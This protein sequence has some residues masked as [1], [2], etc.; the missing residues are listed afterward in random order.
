MAALPAN[1]LDLQLRR[2]GTSSRS[3][4]GRAPAATG[5]TDA[6]AAQSMPATTRSPDTASFRGS[7]APASSSSSS[8]V[9]AFVLDDPL[10]ELLGLP[11]AKT[12]SESTPHG[13]RGN[14][15]FVPPSRVG[16][17][18]GS[19]LASTRSFNPPRSTGTPPTVAA[20]GSVSHHA[21]TG[22]DAARPPPAQVAP[23]A[24]VGSGFVA[25][26]TLALA[27]APPRSTSAQSGVKLDRT[28]TAG[29][30]HL[31]LVEDAQMLAP[32]SLPEDFGSIDDA[33]FDDLQVDLPS[34]PTTRVQSASSRV[35]P[36]REHE[37][38]AP[39]A[40]EDEPILFAPDTQLSS[41]ENESET[42]RKQGNFSSTSAAAMAHPKGPL[43]SSRFSH[44]SSDDAD[45]SQECTQLST[46]PTDLHRV[47][48]LFLEDDV[49][50]F[51]MEEVEV[52]LNGLSTTINAL[53]NEICNLLA[54][55]NGSL[56]LPPDGVDRLAMRERL[57]RHRKV[58][59]SRRRALEQGAPV[60]KM[61]SR[62][63]QNGTGDANGTG[64]PAAT[65]P[66]TL[67]TS[68]SSF[69]LSKPGAV[70]P[71]SRFQSSIVSVVAGTAA[72]P[73]SPF[74]S[75]SSIPPGPTLTRGA[76]AAAGPA[77]P[78][79]GAPTMKDAVTPSPTSGGGGGG[80]VT[81]FSAASKQPQWPPTLAKQTS[82]SSKQQP[83]IG[84]ALPLPLSPVHA[85]ATPSLVDLVS[86]THSASLTGAKTMPTMP[87]FGNA[88]SRMVMSVDSPLST[89]TTT[90]TTRQPETPSVYG[91][92]KSSAA[93]AAAA[94]A[95]LAAAEQDD[96]DANEV[97]SLDG[98]D[99]CDAYSQ[100]HETTDND[101]HTNADMGFNGTSGAGLNGA[102]S[103]GVD[104][105]EFHFD[106]DDDQ[107]F[108]MVDLDQSERL[109]APPTSTIM[110]Y[111]SAAR[112]T[113]TTTMGSASSSQIVPLSARAAQDSAAKFNRTDY[114]WSGDVQ[115]A[116]RKVFGLN[117]GFRTHQL[118]VINCTMS[119][120]HC[121][122]LMPTGGGKSL[123]YQNPAVISKGVTIVVSPLLSL[124]QDQVEALVQLNIGAVFLSGS[125]TEAEQSRVYLEL[126]RQDERCKVVY[127]TPE[128]ISHSTR[129][130]SQLDMLYQSK[131]LARFVIDE[132]HCVSQWGHDF[133]PDYKQ[134][135]MLHDR[136]PT[137]PVMA[138]TATATERV[139]SDI[140][141]QLNIHQAE[142]F[143][144][145]FNRENLRYQVYKKDKTTLDDIAR[146]IKKQWP[147]DSGIVYCLSRK[148][149]ETVAR[150]L[151][152]RGIAATFYHAG[153]DPGDRAV[154]QRDWIGNRK[155][156]IV[157]TIAFGMGI[158]KPDVRYVFHYSLPKSLE[159]Y[160]QESG[161]AG[162]DGYEA[163]CIMYYS[164]GD[165]SKMESMIEKGDSSAEQ[166]RIHKDNLAKMIMYCENVVECRRV[167]QL[168]YFGEKFDR[169][170]CK[171]TCDNCRSSTHYV[172]RDISSVTISVIECV[173]AATGEDGQSSS[174]SSRGTLPSKRFTLLHFVD[175]FRGSNNQRIAQAQHNRLPG[176]GLLKDY[177]RADRLHVNMHDSVNAYVYPGPGARDVLDGRKKI[178]LP[179]VE[180]ARAWTA[181]GGA[182]ASASSSSSAADALAGNAS[183]SS[184]NKTALF[185][186][187]AA[188]RSNTGGA[189]TTTPRHPAVS[190]G[191]GSGPGVTKSGRGS[192]R[193]RVSA[194]RGRRVGSGAVSGVFG[195]DDDDAVDD[196]VDDAFA[197]DDDAGGFA[198]GDDADEDE[199]E[200]AS[201]KPV[202]PWNLSPADQTRIYDALFERRK[203]LCEKS[204][205]MPHNIM[206]HDMMYE[207]SVNL[208][209]D[210]R[211]LRQI[212]KFTVVK[213]KQI[214]E[215]IL[216][217]LREFR[218][219]RSPPAAP[220]TAGLSQAQLHKP[221]QQPQAQ[222]AQ[223]LLNQSK[224]LAG[225]STSRGESVSASS[226]SSSSA[227][228]AMVAASAA[229]SSS[230]SKS[231]VDLELE[232]VRGLPLSL[233]FDDDDDDFDNVAIGT[234][235]TQVAE[236]TYPGATTTAAHSPYW[237]SSTTSAP[238]HSEK[239]NNGGANTLSS[240]L[241]RGKKRA[242]EDSDEQSANKR[243]ALGSGV[244]PTAS[245]A[246]APATK[247]RH[248]IM[249]EDL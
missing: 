81:P 24:Q 63:Q 173:Q 139:R 49:S 18:A 16:A 190:F 7:S 145:S 129:L 146:M 184:S 174:S 67:R 121:L 245:S 119:G 234:Y 71:P 88:S 157:A 13:K 137:V 247:P 75:H 147:K 66:T 208:P 55:Q 10:E 74:R 131:R 151:V 246:A 104:V 93:A 244:T 159:G 228:A 215:D 34:A 150:E 50:A 14:W 109:A 96:D 111:R 229:A 5:R 61:P 101:H 242:A 42:R 130:L 29:V 11:S 65:S 168:A 36:E 91:R 170:L 207:V 240:F 179:F 219:L 76:A 233:N 107:D 237:T 95:A 218:H 20:N 117:K 227:A 160:Y 125:Q 118:E 23:V 1:N 153:M 126:S 58:L 197:Y 39:A 158:N 43:E 185:K 122:V 92:S 217:T 155:Q 205:V 85:Q 112:S 94:A 144:Q 156:V 241:A 202:G 193:S 83:S 249:D 31:A 124:I 212:N 46:P 189:S 98:L 69:L 62:A 136:F 214:G 100:P 35:L 128:K 222:H 108:A 142:I 123:C 37:H 22:V 32:P 80:P 204:N 149:C 152:Q 73:A 201:D 6:S 3:N 161:R 78:A 143:V 200:D 220:P 90:T 165:K 231:A 120:R 171:R 135:R 175:V 198:M 17:A 89:T 77:G 114:P 86:P 40:V 226:S 232:G 225:S 177:A 154:V 239:V 166:K 211:E 196:D 57:L 195:E 243:G 53:S 54:A 176:H 12:T 223:Q 141:K 216:E 45:P 172:E 97:V 140:M 79:G 113:S 132:A 116:M 248:D 188:R 25:A 127:M 192:G 224:G 21:T 48:Q 178:M 41:P 162:R 102:S 134:L 19:S 191:S 8:S 181:R 38:P 213:L 210:L 106:E 163:H 187:P 68:A 64:K 115:K 87:S 105:E 133:R 148:D 186:A 82:L 30:G 9:A 180:T 199:Q 164:Y 72:M 60:N 110:D 27:A 59:D 238:T 209:L 26:S 182:A 169:A 230:S 99:D 52:S 2:L 47:R 4:A 103:R 44:H 15:A 206:T 70:V 236:T 194:G 221:Q 84:Q 203:L 138:L 28:P 33:L 56:P 235:D 167:Q 183:S 51:D